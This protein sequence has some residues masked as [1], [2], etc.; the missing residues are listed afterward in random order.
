MRCAHLERD[1]VGEI[2]SLGT[3]TI[4]LVARLG[5][6]GRVTAA[7]EEVP[8]H[9][10]RC[11]PEI[12]AR[13]ECEVGTLEAIVQRHGHAGEERRSR[14]TP[15]ALGSV[16]ACLHLTQLLA[17]R[18][19]ARDGAVGGDIERQTVEHAV[20]DHLDGRVE[21][22]PHDPVQCPARRKPAL[23]RLGQLLLHVGPLGARAKHRLGRRAPGAEQPLRDAL[24]LLHQHERRLVDLD[25]APGGR[26]L[27]VGDLYVRGELPGRGREL[28]PLAIGARAGHRVVRKNPGVEDWLHELEPRLVPLRQREID[29]RG[30]AVRARELVQRRVRRIY[31]VA[32]VRHAAQARV[33]RLQAKGREEQAAGL[34]YLGRRAAL[35][36]P[37]TLE[38][39]VGAQRFGH[40]LA[41]RVGPLS[42][43]GDWG[44]GDKHAHQRP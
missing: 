10:D 21:R 16:H 36:E 32:D 18:K 29:V 8:R 2:L 17:R 22:S 20:G 11:E 27:E 28:H 40:E 3:G 6:P 30:K 39:E 37:F 43:E 42:L 13:A 9:D 12:V 1:P 14:R 7:V 5:P 26:F 4:G 31:Q 33:A 24:V 34:A 19:R 23:P 38:P 44:H 15:G 25:R 35:G 41:E